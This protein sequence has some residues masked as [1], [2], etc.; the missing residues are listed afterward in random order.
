[1][2]LTENAVAFPFR[3]EEIRSH[4]HPTPSDQRVGRDLAAR[5]AAAGEGRVRSV[6]MIG[7]RAH[8]CSTRSSDLDL[9]VI[10]ET[11]AHDSNWDGNRTDR[12]K[13]RIEREL[14]LPPM[15]TDLTVRSTQQYVDAREVFGGV[16]WL[17]D[18]EGVVLFASPLARKVVPRLSKERVRSGL[19][20][21]WLEAAL[22][23]LARARTGQIASDSPHMIV[24][25]VNGKGLALRPA[26]VPTRTPEYYWHRSIQQALAAACVFHQV[27]AA[28]HDSMEAVA[29]K[30]N[31]HSPLLHERFSNYASISAS[32]STAY[33][34][35][36][37]V[38][39]WVK[40]HGAMEAILKPVSRR[41]Q[42]LR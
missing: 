36:L 33:T 37:E 13:A 41:L 35:V 10:E 32:S 7:S 22:R 2:S 5:I 29:V 6:V 20:V 31:R 40:E 8:G 38:V 39:T 9:V 17:V 19:I 16:E 15:P 12:E 30:L 27:V 3:I 14:G 25:H 11:A 1:M 21:A 18:T 26:S 4:L 34:A 42:E 28:K 24:A 23:S